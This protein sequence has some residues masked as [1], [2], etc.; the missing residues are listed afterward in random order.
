M[1]APTSEP[2]AVP[3]QPAELPPLPVPVPAP[4]PEVPG[5]PVPNG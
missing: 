3:V 4:L 1:P 2:I 5:S